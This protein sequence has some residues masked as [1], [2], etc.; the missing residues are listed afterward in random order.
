[1]A[2]K[3]K[4]FHLFAGG[5]GGILADLLLGHLP[6]G[7]C[8]IEAYPRNVLL[9]RQSDGLLPSFPIWDDVRTLDGNAW[10]GT[11]DV[12]CGGFPCQDISSNG[13]GAGIEGS[14]S[15][16]WK[17]YARL[18]GEMRPRFVFAENTPRLKTKGLTTVLKDLAEMGYDAR[19]C[20]LGA[21]H[22]G[23]PHRRDRLFLLAHPNGS[24]SQQNTCHSK[25]R[26]SGHQQPPENTR[27]PDSSENGKGYQGLRWWDQDPAE[28]PENKGSTEPLLGRVADG[29]ANRMDRITAIGNGQVP[30]CAAMAF[31]LLS[32][33]LI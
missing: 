13:K 17:E 18:V 24:G 26:T 1:M 6:V 12:L 31:D 5:G 16:L 9:R 22:Q 33:G 28:C 11:V 15:G 32:R 8:E 23:A 29:V 3:L 4:T 2:H 21:W 10:R 7:A 30:Q 27:I 14:R 25:L 20:V 19:W